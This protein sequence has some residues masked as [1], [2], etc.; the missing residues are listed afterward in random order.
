MQKDYISIGF[1]YYQGAESGWFSY[2]TEVRR[3][4]KPGSL[5]AAMAS[6]GLPMFVVDLRSVPTGGPVYEWLKAVDQKRGGAPP[7][8][9]RIDALEA[10]DAL[11]HI[12]QITPTQRAISPR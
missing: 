7:A 3:P 9:M 6:V 1:T 5:D 11:F 4:A 2:Q 8:Y 10:W 12:D